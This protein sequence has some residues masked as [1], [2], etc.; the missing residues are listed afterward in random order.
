MFEGVPTLA[1]I[2]TSLFYYLR[3]IIDERICFRNHLFVFVKMNNASSTWF[4]CIF[5]LDIAYIF[6]LPSCQNHIHIKFIIRILLSEWYV[7]FIWRIFHKNANDLIILLKEFLLKNYLFVQID[8]DLCIVWDKRLRTHSRWTFVIFSHN[9]K[10]IR[11]AFIGIYILHFTDIYT[12]ISCI[13]Y[14]YPS[15]KSSFALLLHVPTLLPGDRF[16]YIFTQMIFY[17]WN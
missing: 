9:G 3:G 12:Y 6:V 10:Y 4:F 11:N 2:D 16:R 7:R 17:I 8:E 15:V 5:F 14:Q 1:D 13:P